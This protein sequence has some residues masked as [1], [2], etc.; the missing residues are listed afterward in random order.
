MLK[1][2]IKVAWRN[3]KRS[4]A[5]ST[6]NIMGLALGLTCSILIMLWVQDEYS[7]DAFHENNPRLYH[8]YER[9]FD[10]G[11]VQAD[12]RTQALIAA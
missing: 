8:V 10:D 7:M 3:F 12:Y 2:Y 1:N 11:K 9:R 4:K 6:I 5:F